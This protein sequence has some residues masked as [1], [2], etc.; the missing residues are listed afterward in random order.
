MSKVRTYVET[1]LGAA[2][3]VLLHAG[4]DAADAINQALGEEVANITP[5]EQRSFL[6][7]DMLA[8]DKK[9]TYTDRRTA[10][11][12]TPAAAPAPPATDQPTQPT[13]LQPVRITGDDDYY[14]LPS[15]ALFV[16]PDGV[17]RRKP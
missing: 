12:R 16:G 11:T 8:P 3:F 9:P 7:I 14:R 15:G 5:G 6:G 17:T 13:A 1:Q 4:I 2:G 10:A